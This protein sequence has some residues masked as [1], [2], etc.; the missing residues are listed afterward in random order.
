MSYLVELMLILRIG[1]KCDCK[2]LNW[3]F[4]DKRNCDCASFFID[5]S[6][7]FDHADSLR[8]FAHV[9]EFSLALVMACVSD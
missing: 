7:A 3:K 8:S 9:G 2:S 1:K 6:L 5:V 4:T